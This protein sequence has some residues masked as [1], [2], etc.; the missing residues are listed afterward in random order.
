MSYSGTPDDGSGQ[1][2]WKGVRR[3][4]PQDLESWFRRRL[5]RLVAAS[6]PDW[7]D[8]GRARV[9]AWLA[10]HDTEV[11]VWQDDEEYKGRFYARGWW[12]VDAKLVVALLPEACEA[13]NV[14]Y[15]AER[16]PTIESWLE[17]L[18]TGNLVTKPVKEPAGC[19]LMQGAPLPLAR[20]RTCRQ[21]FA[22]EVRLPRA[23]NCP[24]CRAVA[25]DKI[26]C[27]RYGGETLQ[28]L[29]DRASLTD[30][31]LAESLDVRGYTVRRWCHGRTRYLDQHAESLARIFGLPSGEILLAFFRP[32]QEWPKEHEGAMWG[33]LREL[34]LADG[35]EEP[36]TPPATTDTPPTEG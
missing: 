28:A 7:S 14:E 22:P 21:K 1:R 23:K 17:G 31:A 9:V 29:L 16:Y 18:H 10:E 36:P 13:A 11:L 30:A 2:N 20:C 5:A 15:E 24:S 12:T 19:S 27:A 33:L 4:P 25:R 8:K 34:G 6:I 35:E 3:A 26:Q 32:E